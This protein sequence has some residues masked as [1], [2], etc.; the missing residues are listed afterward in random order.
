MRQ[1]TTERTIPRVRSLLYIRW[2][3]LSKD[4]LRS[5]PLV[6]SGVVAGCRSIGGIKMG[7]LSSQVCPS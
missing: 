6:S 5:S 2:R 3:D 7:F 1:G 4:F